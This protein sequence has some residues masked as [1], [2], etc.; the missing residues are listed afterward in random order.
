M[1]V[2]LG[3]LGVFEGEGVAA[4]VEGERTAYFVGVEGLAFGGDEEVGQAAHIVNYIY[5]IRVEKLMIRDEWI[6]RMIVDIV[7][8]EYLGFN[9]LGFSLS[10]CVGF[11]FLFLSR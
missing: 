5:L 8:D 4:E 10:S 9:H 11:T 7:Y 3:L 2:G 6:I 1:G